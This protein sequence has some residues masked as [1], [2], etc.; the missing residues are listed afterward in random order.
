MLTLG[1]EVLLPKKLFHP[2]TADFVEAEAPKNFLKDRFYFFLG[3]THIT[4]DDL[5]HVLL[6]ALRTSSGLIRTPIII[7]ELGGAVFVGP[8]DLFGG[9][10]T[11]TVFSG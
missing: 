11:A 1:L 5:L 8:S 4:A 6:V 7:E 3:V 9:D 10:R 2:L